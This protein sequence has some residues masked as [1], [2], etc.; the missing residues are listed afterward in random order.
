MMATTHWVDGVGAFTGF[1]TA[2][3]VVVS[4]WWAY[5]KF[6]RDKPD[7]TRANLAVHAEVLTHGRKDLLRAAVKVTAVGTARL[8]L[9]KAE[10]EQP[11]V[12]V[13]RFTEAM[14]DA[15]PVEWTHVHKAREVLRGETM[16]EAGETLEETVLVGLGDRLPG[17]LAYRV[18]F[19]IT[20]DDP[21]AKDDFRWQATD[22]VPVAIGTAAGQNGGEEAK[23]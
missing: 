17:T 15:P 6:L 7:Y 13:Y 4:A 2:A 14:L 1:M 16:V 20:V 18:E 19:S 11:V 23:P 9:V 22:F 10:G 5:R 12:M 3:G 21:V 8:E